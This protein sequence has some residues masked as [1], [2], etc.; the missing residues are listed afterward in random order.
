MGKWF[1]KLSLLT[2]TIIILC[3]IFRPYDA[4]AS[5]SSKVEINATYGI[6]GK[7]KGSSSIPINVE[8]SN[9]TEKDI[10]G[11][12]E[13]R[14][15]SDYG[16]TYDAYAKEVVLG[17]G[18]TEHI[19]IPI[20]LGEENK[21]ATVVFLEKDKEVAKKKILIDSGRVLDY[22][23]FM[24]T[25]TDDF[26]GIS[27]LSDMNFEYDNNKFGDVGTGKV[28]NVPLSL[29]Q[30]GGNIGNF[31]ALDVIVINN[32]S[33]SKLQEIHYKNLENWVKN[34]G[35]LIIG[36][37]VNASKTVNGI[38]NRLLDLTVGGK[39]D[40]SINILGNNLVTTV[41]NLNIN[42][43]NKELESDSDTLIYSVK[44]EKGRIYVATFD[45]G[46]E[47]I[48]SF[49]GN[50]EIWQKILIEDLS[51]ELE[52][53]Q[54]Y[55]GYYYNS[56]SNN[57]PMNKEINFTLIVV[58]F[59]IYVLVI[60]LG[61]YLI[62]KKI[63]KN[64]YLWI[65]I[66][67]LSIVFT[68]AIYGLGSSTR[69]KDIILNQVNI[70][71]VDEDG[72]GTVKGNI[73][74]ANKSKDDLLVEEVEGTSLDYVTNNYGYY[75]DTSSEP[76]KLGVK[77]IYKN[78]KAFY[79]F[80]DNGALNLRN[81]SIIGREES[82]GKL[83]TKLNYVNDGISGT[84]KNNLGCNIEKLF[85]ISG[86]SI[87]DLGEMDEG[88]EIEINKMKSSYNGGLEQYSYDMTNDYYMG[89][90]ND[91]K[92][93]NLFINSQILTSLSQELDNSGVYYIAITDKEIDYGFNFDKKKLS[94]YD[95]TT[96]IGQVDIEFKDENGNLNYPAG[97]FNMDIVTMSQGI[98]IDRGSVIWGNGTIEMDYNIDNNVNV[99]NIG[100]SIPSSNYSYNNNEE[101]EIYNNNTSKYD[102]F[103]LKTGKICDISDFKSY[104]KDNTIRVRIIANQ[105]EGMT[106]PQ[107]SVSGREK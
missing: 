98:S 104:L 28:T 77:T 54:M 34:G 11:T 75:G 44:K 51:K 65:A 18:K 90:R 57:I 95:I 55:G 56:S 42:N 80:K 64:E 63:K 72:I 30:L 68:V 45:L 26:N 60:G 89:N 62:L 35:T 71:N 73:G 22:D 46:T 3:T 2:M 103:E 40:K 74:I 37:G 47:P 29:D 96:M 94:K 61:A 86:S 85:V 52:N 27:Y 14:V 97:Y 20:N 12:V 15:N 83:E 107:I 50:K 25:L 41:A 69:F 79:E 67:V 91:N 88:K 70:I 82:V 24:G 92:Y 5:K 43:S 1:K 4:K 32:F 19:T 105:E 81:F 99:Q 6:E 31:E 106:I 48:T 93:K 36:T 13:I 53:Y 8:V 59:F 7:Y 10:K 21:K 16:D 39:E 17:N 49:H 100:F 38:S 102:K 78:E 9:T 58:V 76:T 87:W 66:P 23:L 33:I 84:I 101:I